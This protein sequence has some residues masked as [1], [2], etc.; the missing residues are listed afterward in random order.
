MWMPVAELVAQGFLFNNVG[1]VMGEQFWIQIAVYLVTGVIAV[2]R[3]SYIVGKIEARC[4]TKED[5]RESAKSAGDT[6]VRKDLCGLAH[7]Q[8]KETVDRMDKSFSDFR[9]DV[10]ATI[11]KTQSMYEVLKD[12]MQEVKEE[13]IKRI[14]VSNAVEKQ[15]SA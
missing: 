15:R 14:N 2:A 3:V 4:V 1:G 10:R 11:T 13:I 12:D 6:F 7:I 8:L 5:L 9:H